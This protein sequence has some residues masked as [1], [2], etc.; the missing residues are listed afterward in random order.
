MRQPRWLT[1]RLF[2]GYGRR[3]PASTRTGLE[4][5]PVQAAAPSRADGPERKPDA[6][7]RPAPPR[8]DFLMIL[9]RSLSAWGT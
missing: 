2:R 9:L 6:E 4:H 1:F 3:S 8:P 7:P 5:L